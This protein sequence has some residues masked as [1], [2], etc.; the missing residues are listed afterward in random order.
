M[1]T[2]T[3]KK[4]PQRTGSTPRKSKTTKA[5]ENGIKQ[6]SSAKTSAV[7]S[8]KGEA[9]SN[10]QRYFYELNDIELLP[11]PTHNELLPDGTIFV[12]TSHLITEDDAPVDNVFSDHQQ[13]LLVEPLYTSLDRW[14]TDNRPF[15]A[16]ADVGIFIANRNPAIVPDA[17]ISMDVK[18]TLLDA[19]GNPISPDFTKIRSYFVWD[20]GKVPDVVI[21]VVSN[22]V[23][24]E[25]SRKMR[26][27]A[28]LHIPFYAVFD[29]FSQYKGDKLRIFKLSGLDYEKHN[30]FWFDTVG[31]GLRL[32]DGDYEAFNTTWLRWCDDRGNVLPTGFEKAQLA[33]Q[34]AADERIKAER[35]SDRANQESDRANQESIKAEQERDRANRFAAKLRELGINPDTL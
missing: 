24:G 12:K 28:N 26:E 19:D 27:Y 5:K 2:S 16:N 23:G 17:F 25:F 32:W 7:K 4:T 31:L 9:F 34:Q 29:P 3:T 33:E 14:N 20:Y 10:E 6:T 30:D 35:E 13:R 8:R 11:E 21:E 15:I 22:R 1:A 18:N